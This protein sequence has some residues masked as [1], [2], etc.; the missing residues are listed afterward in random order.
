VH[1]LIDGTALG[2]CQVRHRPSCN[3]DLPPE[4]GNH[5]YYEVAEPY[6]GRGYGKALLGL[7]LAEAQRIGLERVRLTVLDDNP[8]SRRIIEMNGAVW[9]R[10][11]VARTG[12]ACHLFEIDVTGSARKLHSALT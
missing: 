11:F 3:A 12:E 8:T 5:V 10:G 6:R 1:G 9:L 2:F 4:A 7:A